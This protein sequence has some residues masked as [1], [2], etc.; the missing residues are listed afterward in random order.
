MRYRDC[1]VYRMWCCGGVLATHRRYRDGSSG[2]KKKRSKNV[3]SS[4]QKNGASFFAL[5]RKNWKSIT[6]TKPRRHSQVMPADSG[7]GSIM[8]GN[9]KRFDYDTLSSLTSV[10][11]LKVH[12]A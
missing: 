8:N 1:I 4:D 12:K 10:E 9:V 6:T 3:I 7:G 2:Q 5:K 11:Q